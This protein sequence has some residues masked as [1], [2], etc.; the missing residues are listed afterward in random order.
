MP[1]LPSLIQGGSPSP[2]DELTSEI[3]SLHS[4]P[5]CQGVVPDGE[6]EDRPRRISVAGA[7]RKSGVRKTLIEVEQIA[8]EEEQ[9]KQRDNFFGKL[10]LNVYFQNTTLGVIIF[11][12]A[13]IFVDVEWNHPNLRKENGDLPLEPYSDVIENIFCVYFTAEVLV[14]ALGFRTFC[15]AI[16]DKWFVFDSTLVLMVVLEN[17]ILPLIALIAGSDGGGKALSSFSSFRL[18]RLLR[19]TRMVRIMRFFPELM[20]LIKGMIRAMQSVVFI[21]IFLVIV[22][23]VFAIVFTSQF[24]QPGYIP[25]PNEPYPSSAELFSDIGSSMMTLFTIGVLG[26]N[27]SQTLMAIKAD[28]LVLFWVFV[29]FLVV[30]GM[31]LLNM[32]IGVLCQVIDDSSREEEEMRQLTELRACL[33]EAF[34][35]TD[36]SGDGLVS[37]A[38]WNQ[39]VANENVKNALVKFGIEENMIEERLAQMQETIFGGKGRR[40]SVDSSGSNHKELDFNEFVSQVVELRMDTP[41]SALDLEMLK[42]N[43]RKEDKILNRKLDKIEAELRKTMGLTSIDPRMLPAETTNLEGL[44]ARS[45]KDNHLQLPQLPGQLFSSNESETSSNNE[46]LIY[47]NSSA[48]FNR[49]EDE[50]PDDLRWLREVPTELLFHVLKSRAPPAS[51]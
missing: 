8:I 41:A 6:G 47:P 43:I 49:S 2:A 25:D 24:G 17:W 27:L 40:A 32:L 18:L 30:S 46:A 23:Y 37:E 44:Q 50:G 10:S 39:I 7:D 5:V 28:S 36:T 11:N 14:R 26:D 22:M 48:S 9:S 33:V 42:C 15:F 45:M 12:A 20:T 34:E 21:L 31:T 16:K 1:R 4:E 3:D 19:L 35:G 29:V 51:R 13:W 38:E